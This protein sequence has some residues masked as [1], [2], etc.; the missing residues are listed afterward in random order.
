MRFER[1]GGPPNLQSFFN[2]FVVKVLRG[3]SLDDDFDHEA[4]QGMFPDFA[5]FRGLLL[6]EMK[7]LEADQS[8][9]MQ[10]I[11]ND[12]VAPEERDFFY[13]TIDGR[14]ILKRASNGEE[15]KAA[16]LK[17]LSR[18]IETH[19]SKADKQFI[20]YR[21]RNPRKN[22]VSV[23][24][25]LNSNIP[26]FLPS[27]VLGAV[28]R[29]MTRAAPDGR[30]RFPNIDAVIYISEKHFSNLEDGTAGLGIGIFIGSTIEKEP[31]KEQFIDHIVRNWSIM[32]TGSVHVEVSGGRDVD[33]DVVDD[34]PDRLSRDEIWHL[35]YKRNRYLKDISDIELKVL[36][37]R[38]NVELAVAFIKG[39][40]QKPSED[41]TLAQLR[42]FTHVM[43]EMNLRGIDVRIFTWRSMSSAERVSLFRPG[44]PD[45]IVQM[46][47]A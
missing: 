32:R 42:I 22:S 33:F 14:E 19:L 7:Y 45:E 2:D 29:I 25:L 43:S 41:E 1:Y 27:T 35:E 12:Q 26:E 21:S 44:L 5:C 20:S 37:N 47:S 8:E 6:I 31:W 38:C 3:R 40:W 46:F 23:C 34:I 15:V 9:R 16:I 39:E 18:T 4:S 17:K 28:H 10:A 36:F 13:G 24:V 30:V 11:F